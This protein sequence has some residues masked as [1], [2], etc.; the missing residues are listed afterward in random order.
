MKKSGGFWV[1]AS[2]LVGIHFR[3]GWPTE[4]EGS[5]LVGR[6][7]GPRNLFKGNLGS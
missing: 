2:G 1:L 3:G 6:K 7:M 5:F 4:F